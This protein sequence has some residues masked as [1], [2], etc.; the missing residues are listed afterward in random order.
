MTMDFPR[1]L[2]RP[3]PTSQ[4]FWDALANHEVSIQ[5]CEDCDGWVFYPRT[6]CSHC[7]SPALVWRLIVGTGHIYSYTVAR[8]P[9]APQFADD[10]PQLIAVIELDEGVRLNT[11]M[12]NVEI[13]DLAVGMRVKPVFHAERPEADLGG[14]V[15][16]YFEPA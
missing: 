10:L 7:L 16:L 12:V 13:D 8:R 4:P 14:S 2:P 15:L 11:V 1:P 3:T 5:Q 9:T 6:H